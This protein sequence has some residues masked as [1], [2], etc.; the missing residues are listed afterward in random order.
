MPVSPVTAAGAGGSAN[1]F[2]AK[3]LPTARPYTKWYN[4]H[5]RHSLSEF[6]GEGFIIAVLAVLLVFHL[7]GARVNRS[8]ARGWVRANLAPLASEFAVVGFSGVP[9]PA[10]DKTGEELA[11]A[12]EAMVKGD[13]NR[14]LEE[15]SL[16][17]FAT[18]A[19]GRANVAFVDIKISLVRRFSPLQ[20]IIE[21]GMGFFF[22]AF[23]APSDTMEA[24]ACPFDGQ[25][26][27]IVPGGMPGAHELRSASKDSKSAYDGFV[28]AI[29]NKDH[30]K[31]VR[32]DRY[33]MSITFTKDHARLPVWLTVMSESAEITEALLTKELAAAAEQAGE[34]LDYLIISD[35]PVDKPKT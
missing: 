2:N 12:V 21:A 15:R 34:Y 31:Q 26:A 27:K 19:T 14:Y 10:A 3:A 28:W 22:D 29:V 11:E 25:E 1:L 17:E 24:I 8:R 30:M 35:Q 13:T 9:T 16:F 5:E 20:A 6:Q 32:D 18:Y 4:V 33:D 23:P 7:V